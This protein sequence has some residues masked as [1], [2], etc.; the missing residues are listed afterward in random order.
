MQVTA[1]SRTAVQMLAIALLFLA[2]AGCQKW[3]LSGPGYGADAPRWGEKLRSPTEAGQ[4][5]GLDSRAKEI[6][7]NLGV[8]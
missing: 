6:E 8:R 5:S 1:H 3:N 4:A 7:R 2:T